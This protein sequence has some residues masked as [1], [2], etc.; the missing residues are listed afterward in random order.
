VPW[1]HPEAVTKAFE[2]YEENVVIANTGPAA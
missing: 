1:F 2:S